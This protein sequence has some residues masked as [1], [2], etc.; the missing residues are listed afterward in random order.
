MYIMC[1]TTYTSV[2][3]RVL[4]IRR[5]LRAQTKACRKQICGFNHVHE[6]LGRARK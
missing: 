5:S 6:I 4:S 2:L 1:V 3:A